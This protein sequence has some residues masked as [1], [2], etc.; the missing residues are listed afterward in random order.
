MCIDGCRGRGA[1]PT[2]RIKY[3][4]KGKV[5]SWLFSRN[6]LWLIGVDASNAKKTYF[7][8]S[9]KILKKLQKDKY[10]I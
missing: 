9:T 7:K 10:H 8:M 4:I 3:G 6:P 5:N 1:Y 2:F